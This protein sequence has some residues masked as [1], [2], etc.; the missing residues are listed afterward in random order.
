MNMLHRQNRVSNQGPSIDRIVV[1]P[2]TAFPKFRVLTFSGG[3]W[4]TSCTLCWYELPKTQVYI[5]TVLK[6]PRGQHDSALF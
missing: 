6:W 2:V 5:T 4:G 1:A 3:K